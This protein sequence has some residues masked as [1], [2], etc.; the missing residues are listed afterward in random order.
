M[1]D[2]TTRRQAAIWIGGSFLFFFAGCRNAD[3]PPSR[4]FVSVEPY[5]SRATARKV[6]RKTKSRAPRKFT[7]VAQIHGL[8]AEEA[9]LQYPV[10]LRGVITFHFPAD[11]T[12]FLQDATG[13]IYVDVEAQALGNK[14]LEAGQRVELEGLTAPGEFAP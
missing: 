13:G 10:H 7:A 9:A 6:E 1:A 11:H 12:L 14:M 4:T 3:S 2:V 8:T 5:P